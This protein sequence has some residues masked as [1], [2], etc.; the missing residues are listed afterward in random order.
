[1]KS[2]TSFFLFR[3]INSANC[4]CVWTKH[5]LRQTVCGSAG[6]WIQLSGVKR[7]AVFIGWESLFPAHGG[8]LLRLPQSNILLSIRSPD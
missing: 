8:L 1:M 7:I 2:Y 6:S 4:F 5:S 3:F